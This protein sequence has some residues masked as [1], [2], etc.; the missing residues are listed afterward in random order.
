MSDTRTLP[1]GPHRP[2]SRRAVAR[3]LT[4][5]R[6][7]VVVAA[8]QA[9]SPR[10]SASL[11]CLPPREDAHQC[12]ASFSWD[13]NHSANFYGPSPALPL[14]ATSP[15]SLTGRLALSP[16]VDTRATPPISSWIQYVLLPSRSSLE[17][18]GWIRIWPTRDDALTLDLF[19]PSRSLFLA[20]PLE[21]PE[22]KQQ[23]SYAPP[24][25]A[26]PPPNYGG[27]H[28]SSNSH[29]TDYKPQIT[30]ADYED[31]TSA[32]EHQQHQSSYPQQQTHQQYA[33]PQQKKG[34]LGGLLDKLKGAGGSS[35]S[36]GQQQ[37]GYPQQQ[38][39]YPQQG[40]GG[41]M[42]SQGGMMGGGMMAGHGAQVRPA[43][44]FLSSIAPS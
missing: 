27:S 22:Y 34:G 33:Q 30:R 23:Q 5:A 24:T 21:L 3:K 41:G 35:S 32:R 6:P 29:S 36:H 37:H 16:T 12:T 42:M 2:R 15:R 13:S 31:S 4:P 17:Q 38:H 9:G 28:A 18:L 44:P 1:Q 10:S 43:P 40:H 8:R 26:P 25:G 14:T 20:S 39:G 7:L 11:F 19:D